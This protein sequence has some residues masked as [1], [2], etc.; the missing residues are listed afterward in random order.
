MK[1][2][3][4]VLLTNTHLLSH[5]AK[6]F[7]VNKRFNNR[8]WKKFLRKYNLKTLISI[9]PS[10]SVDLFRSDDQSQLYEALIEGYKDNVFLKDIY[11]NQSVELPYAFFEE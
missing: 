11:R 5:K 9:S 4:D 7:T 6:L 2:P 1:I 8:E 10:V 3:I